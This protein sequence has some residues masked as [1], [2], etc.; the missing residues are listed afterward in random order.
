[1]LAAFLMIP[2]SGS[3]QVLMQRD[4]SLRMAITIAEAALAECGINTSVAVVDRA[5]RLRALL[6]GDGASPH[7][8]T[9]SGR[10]R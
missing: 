7:T 4:V 2:S 3:G 10:G 6:Q 1:M 9:W 8:A 5:G